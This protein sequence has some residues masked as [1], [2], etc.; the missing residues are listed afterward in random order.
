[1]SNKNKNRKIKYTVRDCEIEIGK[2]MSETEYLTSSV[3]NKQ[4]LDSSLAK[5]KAGDVIE[6]DLIEDY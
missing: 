4:R 2:P 6:K 3:K 5:I 1:M